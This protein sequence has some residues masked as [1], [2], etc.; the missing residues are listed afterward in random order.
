MGVEISSI[1]G[2]FMGHLIGNH[3]FGSIT[4]SLI[5]MDIVNFTVFGSICFLCKFTGLTEIRA[6]TSELKNFL[7]MT[8]GVI[9]N[10]GILSYLLKK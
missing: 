8:G 2:F 4:T 10:Y 1:C 9:I 6:S 7:L 3:I 5:K